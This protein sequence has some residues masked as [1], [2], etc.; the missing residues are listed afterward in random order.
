MTSR[1]WS[2][3]LIAAVGHTTEHCPHCTQAEFASPLS[4]KV[5]TL[6]LAPLPEKAMA[7]TVWVSAQTA[8]QRPHRMHFESSRTRPSEE[9]SGGWNRFSLGK[10]AALAPSDSESVRNSQ[11]PARMHDRQ[12]AG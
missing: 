11:V 9:L 4:M 7:C 8:T 2:F 3:S 5:V 10:C 12:S 6:V 1:D